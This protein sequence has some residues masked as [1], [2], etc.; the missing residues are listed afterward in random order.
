MLTDRTTPQ[1]LGVVLLGL[2]ALTGAAC[3]A[4]AAAKR[5]SASRLV[6]LVLA[7]VRMWWTMCGVLLAA[8]LG[9]RWGSVLV[10][11][12][13]S[14][15]LLREFI[16]MTP[17]RRGDHHVLF[18]V[19]F[20]ILPLQYYFLGTGWYGMFIITIPVYA[21]LLIP[22]RA[23]LAG[24][25]ERFLERTAKIQWGLM[26]C[27]YCVAHAPAL[28][29][30]EVPDYPGAGLRLLVFLTVVVQVSDLIQ[31]LMETATTREEDKTRIAVSFR[32]LPLLAG[33]GAAAVAG[34]ALTWSVPFTMGQ[35]IGMALLGSLAGAGGRL[36]LKAIERDRGRKGVVVAQTRPSMIERVIPLSFAAPVF[37]HVTRY[38][39]LGGPRAGF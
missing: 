24:D 25:P 7:R 26:I 15:L 28:L 3:V 4:K 8:M 6:S 13:T 12:L 32:A 21:F 20:V 10:F 14:F 2:V 37:F 30:L 29:R 5:D 27:V 18:W 1:L 22:I 38:F 23:A 39:V 31:R 35:S 16:T 33:L 34:S 19:F 11:A 36:C 17:T 9:G